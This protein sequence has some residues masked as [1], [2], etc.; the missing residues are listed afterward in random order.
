MTASEL[1]ARF[2]E[3]TGV[4]GRAASRRYLWTDAFA[5][6]NL[7]GLGQYDH[8]RALIGRVH[9]ELGRHR[10][11]D[12]VR[13]GWISGLSETEG[14]EHPTLGG[15]R[16]GKPLPERPINEPFDDRLEWDRDGQY[17]HY[18][19]KWM[20]ALGQAASAS[21][22]PRLAGWARE[23]AITAHQRFVVAR[24]MYWKMSIDLMRPL[25]ASMGHHDPLDGYVT[26]LELRTTHEQGPD[27]SRAIEDFR[28]M[29]DAAGLA[30]IDPLGIGGLL[31]D[32]YRLEQLELD[33]PLRE[34]ILAAARLGFAAYVE[35]RE[36]ARPAEYRLAFRELGLAIG[37]S[38]IEAMKVD[39]FAQAEQ[40][41][42]AIVDF[43][44]D[45]AHQRSST[46]RGHQDINDVMLATSLEPRGFLALQ[47]I[48]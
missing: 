38:G 32:A 45:P 2:T 7:L 20:H 18:L 29:V 1:M 44:A 30:T 24:R 8:A 34:A 35:E 5:V 12:E 13:R 40:V 42:R 22:E 48:R 28:A 9:R 41:R 33:V 26:C 19:T 10:T 27:L 37:L 36:L 47:H 3:R 16:I 43:W 31:F 15:L 21:H 4:V 11:D 25:V 17:F 46:Y 14:E 39:G 23:L 6:C